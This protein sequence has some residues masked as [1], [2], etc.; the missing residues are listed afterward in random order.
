MKDVSQ[1]TNFYRVTLKDHLLYI[2]RVRQT[3]VIFPRRLCSNNLRLLHP[4]ETIPTLQKLWWQ[5]I[6]ASLLPD[7]RIQDSLAAVL[8]PILV[9]V[10]ESTIEEYEEIILPV[11]RG[12]FSAPKTVQATVTILENLHIIL[13]KTSRE[14]IRAEMFAFLFNSFDS[15]T[16]QV[17]VKMGAM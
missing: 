13:A 2:P 16:I 8:Q 14:D 7:L 5:H 3:F 9:L 12:L 4:C 15:T 17:Q 1:K 11:F 6:W 10:K